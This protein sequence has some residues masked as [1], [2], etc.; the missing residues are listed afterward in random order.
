MDGQAEALNKLFYA[1]EQGP[2]AYIAARLA[3]LRA[4]EHPDIAVVEAVNLL[5][6]AAEALVRHYLAHRKALECPWLELARL[7][8][9]STFKRETLAMRDSTED[10]NSRA[11]SI[12]V[13]CGPEGDRTASATAAIGR[14]GPG[15][16]ALLRYAADLLLDEAGMYNAVKHGIAAVPG[17]RTLPPEL[18]NAGG[19]VNRGGGM[20]LLTLEPIADADGKRWGRV[21]RYVEVAE[22][23]AII[24]IIAQQLENLWQVARARYLGA[25]LGRLN[26]LTEDQVH[27]AR[28]VNGL[29]GPGFV[30]EFAVS[31]GYLSSSPPVDQGES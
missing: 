3:A 23:I 25:P 28:H 13:F 9:F 26:P 30:A 10:A 16:A 19:L 29:D 24:E 22:N 11:E 20:S 7:R 14:A 18:L 1:R 17:M 5:H 4:F 6:H 12:A 8:D 2:H 15:L 31:L 27:Q 21:V